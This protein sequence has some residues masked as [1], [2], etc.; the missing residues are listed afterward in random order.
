MSFRR[1]A[2]RL[3]IIFAFSAVFNVFVNV[4]LFVDCQFKFYP[5]DTTSVD[6]TDSAVDMAGLTIRHGTHVRRA[7]GWKGGPEE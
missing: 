4:L 6:A 3:P 2:R 7:P 5:C 1:N